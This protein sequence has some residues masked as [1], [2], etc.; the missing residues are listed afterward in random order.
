MR[1]KILTLVLAALSLGTAVGAARAEDALRMPAYETVKLDNGLTV[2]LMRHA[3][4]PT[5]TFE[6]WIPAGASV[7]PA[8]KEGLANL[9]AES[10]RKGAGMRDAQAFAQAVDFPGRGLQHFRQLRPRADHAQRSGQGLRVRALPPR[11]RGARSAL[12]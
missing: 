8:G 6:M 2:Q 11:R 4:V 10:L 7:D 3:T 12:R 9:T 1:T 5:V